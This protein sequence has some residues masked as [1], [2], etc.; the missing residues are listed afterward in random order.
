MPFQR[1]TERA[2]ELV[3]E[4]IR[5]GD[6]AIDATV[7]NGHDTL[8]LAELVGPE[9][10]VIGYDTQP[11]AIDAARKRLKDAGVSNRVD[12]RQA[13]HES[14]GDEEEPIRVV[15]FNLGYF[16]GGDKTVITKPETTIAAIR[17]ALARLQAGGLVTVVVYPGHP[18]GAEE[19]EAVLDFCEKLDQKLFSV[20][21]YGFLNQ[22]NHPPF[23]VAVEK[24]KRSGIRENSGD[25]N[26]LT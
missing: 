14:I 9:G 24:R 20:I 1:A 6:T 23:L 18:G 17:S 26:L 11:E 21:R 2:H 19:G 7:G 10:R 12:L 13:S 5:L 25:V 4:R 3:R 16:P 8:F 22:V 15:M